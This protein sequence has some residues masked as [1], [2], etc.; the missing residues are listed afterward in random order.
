MPSNCSY[1]LTNSNLVLTISSLL[2]LRRVYSN[3]DYNKLLCPSECSLP[4]CVSH[5]HISSFKVFIQNGIFGFF[6]DHVFEYDT[7]VH[8]A[9]LREM[10]DHTHFARLT[11]VRELGFLTTDSFQQG[12][13]E[14]GC[15][16]PRESQLVSSALFPPWCCPVGSQGNGV[17]VLGKQTDLCT[18]TSP[19]RSNGLLDHALRG[20]K[21]TISKYCSPQK[22]RFAP[23]AWKL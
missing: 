19:V 12:F 21:V 9:P 22:T 16:E 13:A 11:P 18:H 3:P 8:T 5:T 20:D 4:V 10:H 2:A 23:F 1:S 7:H 15:R 6:H 14:S 17:P